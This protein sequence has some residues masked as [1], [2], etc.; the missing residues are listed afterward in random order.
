[1]IHANIGIAKIY[2]LLQIY[3]HLDDVSHTYLRSNYG[4]L[5]ALSQDWPN[6]C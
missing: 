4:L 3:L 5:A 1:M 6:S 2:G